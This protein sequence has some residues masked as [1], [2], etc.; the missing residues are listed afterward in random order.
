MDDEDGASDRERS[1]CPDVNRCGAPAQTPQPFSTGH[2]AQDN[3]KGGQKL[4]N[5]ARW[6]ERG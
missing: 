4:A 6:V 2:S 3:E 5:S 1:E